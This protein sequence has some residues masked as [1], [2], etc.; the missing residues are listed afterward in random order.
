M[1]TLSKM[2]NIGQILETKLI[3][4]GIET[5]EQLKKIG[6]METFK[7]IKLIDNTACINMLCAIE[8]AIQ[9][10]RWHNL[11]EEKKTE[12]KIFYSTLNYNS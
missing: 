6:S 3:Q 5:P 2:P 7:R 8:G 11:S 4:V 10:I 9:G 12:L 1:G